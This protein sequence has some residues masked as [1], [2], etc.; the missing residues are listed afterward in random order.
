MISFF[1]KQ[2]HLAPVFIF[3]LIT[4]MV[5]PAQAGHLSPE[6]IKEYSS[7]DPFSFILMEFGFIVM[8]ALIGHMVSRQYQLPEMLGELMIG[9]LA[10]NILYWIDLSPVFY[11]LMHLGD[12]SE[13]FK[14]IWTSNMSVADTVAHYFT[15]DQPETQEFVDRLST[16]FT[17][18]QSPGLILL[19]VALWIFSN[20]GVF[21]LLFKLGLE[22]KTEEIINAAEPLAFLVS[23]TG[24]FVPFFLG[25]GAGLWLL[26][27]ASTSMHIFIA[28]A[29]CTTSAVA[30]TRIFTRLNRQQS[31]EARLV[32]HAAFLD[33]IFGMFF[34][35]YIVNIVLGDTLNIAEIIALLFY[36]GV[37]FIGIIMLGKW[38]IRQLPELH[39][40]D[41]LHIRILLPIIVVV[42]VSWLADSLGIGIIS[43]SFIAGMILNTMPDKEGLIKDLIVPLEKIFAPVFFVFVGMQ[44]NLQ[45]LIKPEILGLTIVFLIVAVAG[46]IAAGYVTRKNINHL[47]V[48]LGMIPRG[49]AVLIF[50]SIGKILSVIDDTMF[51]VITI[52]VLITNFIAPWAINRLCAAKCHD[53]SF[54]VKAS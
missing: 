11:M 39:Q 31:R 12:A 37:V 38:L 2:F 25:L 17:T 36:S 46:K 20:F 27:E 1:K 7:M 14:S 33:D 54:A 28:A 42:M 44:V 13:I 26:P 34:L 29:L 24:T 5:L 45:L 30:T 53:D 16:V 18:N 40:Y 52:I 10:G 48:G 4:T 21:F 41:E 49:E 9:V 15:P 22:T 3:I 23:A 35:S 19:G 43:S 32:I 51:S 47:A 6:M 50:I 8:L